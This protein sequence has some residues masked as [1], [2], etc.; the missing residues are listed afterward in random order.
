MLTN[1]ESLFFHEN[2]EA[3]SCLRKLDEKGV[4][5]WAVMELMIEILNLINFGDFVLLVKCIGR[6]AVVSADNGQ[7]HVAE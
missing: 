7:S 2:R 1:K 5:I 4:N 3:I 6:Q